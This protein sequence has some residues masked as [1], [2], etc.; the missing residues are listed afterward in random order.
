MSE[1][2]ID[3]IEGLSRAELEAVKAALAKTLAA[4]VGHGVMVELAWHPGCVVLRVNVATLAG[5]AGPSEPLLSAA[6]ILSALPASIRAKIVSC[7]E[8]DALASSADLE[9]FAEPVG[10]LSC[11]GTGPSNMPLRVTLEAS[12]ASKWLLTEAGS[13][14]P[15]LW[16]ASLG[17]EVKPL[18]ISEPQLGP[19]S[20]SWDL[21]LPG[22]AAPAT[23]EVTMGHLGDDGHVQQTLPQ[24]FLVPVLC[25][26]QCLAELEALPAL[27]PDLCHLLVALED[28]A[29][30]LSTGDFA[31]A[32][33][34]HM[35][36]ELQLAGQEHLLAMLHKLGVRAEGGRDQEQQQQPRGSMDGFL[37]FYDRGRRTHVTLA[38]VERVAASFL[39]RP[40]S[41]ASHLAALEGRYVDSKMQMSPIIQLMPSV[42]GHA[43]HAAPRPVL[44]IPSPFRPSCSPS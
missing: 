43:L 10:L 44:T 30:S 20:V 37:R 19:G 25:S 29:G 34:A 8:M 2:K 36:R 35:I 18:S 31:E 21:V 40:S 39:T 27:G 12:G 15:L 32:L 42:R 7:R 11:P 38:Q 9:L 17:H 33:G 3:G 24:S 22:I 5:G 28:P 6:D 13:L 16:C 26:R 4:K 14:R 1:V 41:F 23:L